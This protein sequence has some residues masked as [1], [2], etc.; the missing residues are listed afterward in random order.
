LAQEVSDCSRDTSFL[1]MF[2]DVFAE[3]VRAWSKISCHEAPE[4]LS[5]YPQ[6]VLLATP[7]GP[8]VAK[9]QAYHTSIM[10]DELE[11]SFSPAGV[12]VFRGPASHAACPKHPEK[13]LIINMGTTQVDAK[14]FA[15]KMRIFFE[16]G[17][18][19]LL[20]KNCNSFS[21][22]GLQYLVGRRLDRQFRQMEK[23][24]ASADRYSYVVQL[25]TGGAYRPNPEADR[26]KAVQVVGA[27][28]AEGRTL[29]SRP[30]NMQLQRQHVIK[31]G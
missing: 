1:A 30:Q 28:E 23:V 7:I 19:D 12:S 29:L 24:G 17:S 2:T 21:D 10:L 8:G 26:F 14:G 11:Y 20:R 6:V 5:Y 15:R 9:W 18:Y 4:E 3:V 25:T 22:V 13:T 16:E 31:R 27:L